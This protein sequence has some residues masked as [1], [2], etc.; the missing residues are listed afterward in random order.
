MIA[1][2]AYVAKFIFN[3]VLIDN[4]IVSLKGK[5]LSYVMRHLVTNI[6]EATTI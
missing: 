3:V 5:F 4:L 6:E 1:I 2:K